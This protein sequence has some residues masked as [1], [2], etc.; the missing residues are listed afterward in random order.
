ML[1]DGAAREFSEMENPTSQP[2]PLLFR[3]TVEHPHHSWWAVP[4][5]MAE[6]PR[7]SDLNLRP[8]PN[9]PDADGVQTI[10]DRLGSREPRI[11]RR[12]FPRLYRARGSHL[13]Q[14]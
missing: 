10:A 12:V 3:I 7:G 5:K 4:C 13:L 14:G 8:D 1:K 11:K 6:I 9:Q 2:R